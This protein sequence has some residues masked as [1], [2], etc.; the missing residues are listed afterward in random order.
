MEAPETKK[1]RLGVGTAVSKFV[2]GVADQ[3]LLVLAKTRIEQ[4]IPAMGKIIVTRR[5]ELLPVVLRVS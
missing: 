5:Q 3:F 2:P 4:L 1:Q